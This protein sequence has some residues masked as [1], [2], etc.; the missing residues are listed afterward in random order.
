MP[1][2]CSCQKT[3][4][5]PS[6]CQNMCN[7]NNICV[8][9]EGFYLKREMCVPLDECTI[10]TCTIDGVELKVGQKCYCRVTL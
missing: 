10:P 2:D 6:G 4:T 7:A 3:C 9:A 8:C 1:G 5:N